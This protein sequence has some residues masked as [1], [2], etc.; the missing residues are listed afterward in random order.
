MSGW[1]VPGKS[2]GKKLI[3]I[4]GKKTC[5][6]N[7]WKKTNFS[8][9]PGKSLKSHGKIFCLSQ[10]RQLMKSPFSTGE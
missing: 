3:E 1:P 5:H 4:P 10:F 2:W 9:S 6:G 8:K 7:S